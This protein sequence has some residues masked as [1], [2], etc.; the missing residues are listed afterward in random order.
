MLPDVPAVDRAFDYFAAD[1]LPGELSVGSLVRIPFGGRR[2]AGWVLALDVE[3]PEG[4]ELSAILK[5]VGFGPDQTMIDLC[6]WAAWR[7]SGRLTTMLRAASPER[8]VNRLPPLRVRPAT[9]G[10][11]NELAE[12]ILLLG[13]GNHVLQVSPSTD[14]L[15]IVVAAARLGQVLAIL[16]TIAESQRVARGL[17]ASGAAVAAWPWDFQVAA[18]GASVVGGRGAA[19]APAPALA[20]VV[21]ID[22]HDEMLQSESS[23][24]WNAR[25]IAIERA[26]QAQVPCLLVSPCPSLEALLAQQQ[27][28]EFESQAELAQVGERFLPRPLLTVDVPLEPRGRL[29][30]SEERSGWA[31]LTVLDRRGEDIGRTGLF[32]S[33]LVEMIRETARSGERVVCVLNR[34]GRARL[35]ACRSCGTLAECERCSAAVSQDDNGRLVCTRCIQE[36][37]AICL[38]CGSMALSILRGGVTRAREELEALAKEPVHAITAASPK[39]AADQPSGSDYSAAARIFI[40]TQAVLHRLQD[41]SLVAFLDFDQEL[42]APRYRAAEEALALLM[43][44][45]RLVGGREAGRVGGREAGRVG[46]REAGRVGGREAGGRVVVQ[47]RRPDHESIQAALRA[48]PLLV[49]FSEAQRRILLGFP[50]AAAIAQV[51]YEAAPEFIARLGTPQGVE[52]QQAEDGQW[53][54]RSRESGRL[55]EV[56]SQVDRPVGRL[57]LQVDPARL[58]S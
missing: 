27:S 2:V 49:S 22:E 16:P 38:E 17:R 56:L 58:R 20:A 34:T 50:P 30:R 5:I 15:S 3:P 28:S 55:Q 39:S 21:V 33:R 37:P 45:S 57:R 1:D 23:P 44:S 47:T 29:S 26:R 7:W 36:R 51:G 13:A 42:L 40:G 14:P 24:T 53:L 18:G 41:V 32:S 54:L 43:L 46:G 9:G 6:R 12:S 8:V 19:F 10:E 52:V 25:D 48:E 11:A 4:V 35:L 31:A